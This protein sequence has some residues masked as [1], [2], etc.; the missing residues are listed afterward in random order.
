MQN[1]INFGGNQRWA[2]VSDSYNQRLA[3]SLRMPLFA[4]L[5]FL[6]ESRMNRIGHAEF[7]TGELE[8]LLPTLDRKTGEINYPSKN[9]ICKALRIAIDE[10]FFSEES[11]SRCLVF[12]SNDVQRSAK[13]SSSCNHHGV[14]REWDGAVQPVSL[15]KAEKPQEI[16][17]VQEPQEVTQ[18]PET[19]AQVPSQPCYDKTADTQE[20]EEA[21]PEKQD[22]PIAE[23]H[24]WFER[25][26]IP[27]VSKMTATYAMVYRRRDSYQRIM[28][29][30][31][32]AAKPEY[33]SWG[34]N[35]APRYTYAAMNVE[36]IPERDT[37]PLAIIEEW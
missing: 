15:V 20:K 11:S 37:R 5:V 26:E 21:M 14:K 9:T 13:A 23:I 27:E 7:A 35:W 2:A 32:E 36:T 1:N 29:V 28:D 10:G 33:D 24:D 12:H 16:T 4:R 3:G 22:S 30:S 19:A 31:E 17:E 25:D 34:S 6:A 18:E 8:S